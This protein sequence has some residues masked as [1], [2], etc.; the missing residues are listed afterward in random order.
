ML[1][2]GISDLLREQT[3]IML[4]SRS[5]GVLTLLEVGGR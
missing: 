2:A 1:Y 3:G 5:A 4:R